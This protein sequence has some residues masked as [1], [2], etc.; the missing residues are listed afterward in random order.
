VGGKI[1]IFLIEVVS[2]AVATLLLSDN[3]RIIYPLIYASVLATMAL[4]VIDPA[5]ITRKKSVWVSLGLSV[6]GI[7]LWWFDTNPLICNPTSLL[8]P[9]AVW[10]VLSAVSLGVLFESV[11]KHRKS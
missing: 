6:V 4:F 11:Q 7:T 1:T 9:H 5:K 3:P 10:H 2:V 8:Q